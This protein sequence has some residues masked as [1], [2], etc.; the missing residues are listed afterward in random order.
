M[1][2]AIARDNKFPYAYGNRRFAYLHLGR[3][4]EGKADL[5]RAVALD[6][7]SEH[8]YVHRNLGVYYLHKGDYEVAV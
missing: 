8:G 3:L 5:D 2:D 4:E 6:P 7:T 1:N